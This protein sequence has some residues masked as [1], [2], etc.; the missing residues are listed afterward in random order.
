MFFVCYNISGQN[1]VFIMKVSFP[2]SGLNCT[3][4]EV[5]PASC[6]SKPQISCTSMTKP[7]VKQGY[8]NQE[9]YEG[10]MSVKEYFDSLFHRNKKETNPVNYLV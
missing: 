7:K 6:S 2:V 3:S 5:L 1:E 10:I 8:S 9:I 4:K